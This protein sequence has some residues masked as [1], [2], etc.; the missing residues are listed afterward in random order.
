MSTEGAEG[1]AHFENFTFST[2]S[3]TGTRITIERLLALGVPTDLIQAGDLNAI[4]SDLESIT[5]ASVYVAEHEEGIDGRIFPR[6]E[7]S[8]ITRKSSDS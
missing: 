2:T 3:T 4:A 6:Y 7:W 1:I 8:G 5:E